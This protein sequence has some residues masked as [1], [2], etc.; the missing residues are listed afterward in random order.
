MPGRVSLK[1]RRWVKPQLPVDHHPACQH[2]GEA[3]ALTKPDAPARVNQ[4]VEVAIVIWLNVNAHLSI[5]EVDQ[6]VLFSTQ[7]NPVYFSE[8][9]ALLRKKCTLQI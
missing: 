1:M 5:V 7:K 3:E 6:K 2:C 9:Q 8:P 4:P